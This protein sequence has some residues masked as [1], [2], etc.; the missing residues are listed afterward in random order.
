MGNELLFVLS[1][2]SELYPRLLRQAGIQG[3][4]LVRAI[5]DSTG[6]AEPQSVQV[7]ATP[8]PGFEQA[9]RNLVLQ[10]RF[11][12]GRFRERPV[13]VVIE[14]RLDARAGG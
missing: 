6:H 10:A 9:A 4:V 13:R 8:H 14:F 2:P 5:I 12:Q 11:H 1:A 7:I 3:Q